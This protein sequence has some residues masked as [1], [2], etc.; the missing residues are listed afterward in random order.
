MPEAAKEAK[1]APVAAKRAGK[2]KATSGV[3]KLKTQRAAV[4]RRVAKR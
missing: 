4:K 2:K 3:A 1:A